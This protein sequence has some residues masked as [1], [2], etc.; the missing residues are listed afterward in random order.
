ME[1]E[2]KGKYKK[3]LWQE[4]RNKTK[5]TTIKDDKW[6]RKKYIEHCKVDTVKTITKIRVQIRNLKKNHSK[7]GEQPL[8]SLCET[9]DDT[10]AWAL[11]WKR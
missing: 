6:E 1:K 5:P 7:E 9:E 4:M 8:T 11:L 3:K 2:I 10:T